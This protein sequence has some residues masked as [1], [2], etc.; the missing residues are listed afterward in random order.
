MAAEHPANPGGPGRRPDE[1]H[2]TRTALGV[3]ATVFGIGLIGLL[4]VPPVAFPDHAA[5]ERVA[6]FVPAARDQL[7][8]QLDPVA[9]FPVYFR[10][11]EARCST[12]GSGGI[13]LLF[14]ELRPPYLEPTIAYTT[15]RGL[16]ASPEDAWSGGFG[17]RSI[18]DDPEFIHLMGPGSARC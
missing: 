9:R 12:D 18:D 14:E 3:A 8:D 13:A 16:P 17:V 4:V 10:F 6:P 11:L 2:R 7:L 1:R 15:R 5:P